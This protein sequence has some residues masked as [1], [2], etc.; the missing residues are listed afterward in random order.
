[1][2]MLVCFRSTIPPLFLD[3]AADPKL[4]GVDACLALG[5]ASGI[6]VGAV[7]GDTAGAGACLEPAEGGAAGLL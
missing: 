6:G 2:I 1:M 3:V 5:S 7:A 4:A